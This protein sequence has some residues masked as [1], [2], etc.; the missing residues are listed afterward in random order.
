LLRFAPMATIFLGALAGGVLAAVQSPDA[1]VAFA[2]APEIG[3]SLAVIKGVW[4][5]LATGYHVETGDAAID[6][7]MSRGGM[8]SMM[9]TVWLIVCALAFGA[10]VE[11]G[12][13]LTRLVAPLLRGVRSVGG[14]VTLLVVSCIGANIITSDQYI[15][16]VLPG[17]LFRA[18]F[19]KRGLAPVFLS[20]VIGDSAIVTSPLVPWNSCGAY[21]AATLGVPTLGYAAFCF[22]N[23][24]NPALTI[25]FSF[26]AFRIIR[27]G[28][29]VNVVES[30]A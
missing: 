9:V 30:N 25:L 18:E 14:L 2:Q 23:L 17:R 27:T 26:C 3:R 8:S 22:F 29:R 7:L 15:A 5:A 1:V 21:M 10:A 4:S 20:R 11:H 28:E 13:F 19:L 16:V 12:G 6:Q 24:L